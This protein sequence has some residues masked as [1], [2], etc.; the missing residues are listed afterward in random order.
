MSLEIAKLRNGN[1]A[2][3]TDELEHGVISGIS[4]FSVEHHLKI[5]YENQ[6]HGRFVAAPLPDPAITAIES[7]LNRVLIVE[8]GRDPNGYY[9]P[10]YRIAEQ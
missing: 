7:A 3:L 4:Y 10:F 6:K 1:I 2:I 8:M 9:V 5:D